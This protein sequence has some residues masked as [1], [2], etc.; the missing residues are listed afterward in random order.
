MERFSTIFIVLMLIALLSF[1][2]SFA[3]INWIKHPNPVL[4]PGDSGA[5]DDLHVI[6]A[7]VISLNDTLHMWYDANHGDENTGSAA[8]GPNGVGHAI[9][10]DGISWIKDTLNPVLTPG[11]ASWESCW[12]GQVSVLYNTSD[13]LLHMWYAGRGN[14]NNYQPVY[15]GHATSQDGSNW[16]KD[17]DWALG[18]GSSGQWDDD[19]LSGPEV[20]VVNDTLHMWYDGY[21][22]GQIP[23][24][25]GHAISTDWITWEKDPANPVLEPGSV[26][27]WDYPHVRDARVICIDDTFHMFYNGGD[28]PNYDIGYAQS[29]N[30]SNWVKY[31]ESTTTE[32]PYMNSD[33]VLKRGPAGSWDEDGVWT[34]SVLFNDNSDSLRMWY[35][36]GRNLAPQ[37]GYATAFFDPPDIIPTGIE[38]TFLGGFPKEYEL[39]HNYPNPF[40]PATNIEFSITKSEFVE[41]RVY[42][43]LGKEVLTVVSKKLDQ[44]NNTYT[45][46][47]K[48]LASGIY[49]YQLIAGEYREVKK[50]I[51]LR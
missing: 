8:S 32:N 2:S 6:I 45:F 7:S 5:W 24:K 41:L 51:L 13:S 42:N 25:T 15:I 17:S 11:P 20:I 18:P 9:S 48:N 33:P 50:M 26:Q 36:G 43:I 35:S 49:Y 37:I 47:G 39:K 28:H 38:D 19:A 12:V 14:C 1:N 22:L 46:S 29:S 10:T 34:G 31:D 30:G 21:K 44:G 3:Q 27:D 4:S 40:N 16:T 23:P